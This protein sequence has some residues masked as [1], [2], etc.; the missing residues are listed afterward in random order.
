MILNQGKRCLPRYLP[1][2]AKVHTGYWKSAIFPPWVIKHLKIEV[3][4]EKAGSETVTNIEVLENRFY[5][6]VVDKATGSISS[7]FDKELNH[8][9]L[10]GDNPYNIGQ[11]VRETTAERN[12]RPEK[13]GFILNHT[14]VSNIKVDKGVNGPVWESIKI[15]FDLDGY[16][17]GTEGSPR[18]SRWRSDYYKNIKKIEFRYM[19]RKLIV[20]DPEALY[21]TFPFSM[22]GSRIVFE[23][24]GGT[25]TQGQ[26]L[27][28]SSSDWNSAQNFVAVRGSSGQI[29]IVSN[30]VPMWQFSDFNMGKRERNPKQ[31][32]TWLYSWVMNNYWDTNFR[33][34]QEGGFSWSYQITSSAD[35][36]NT[37]AAKYAW[38]ERNPFPARTFPAGANDL[39]ST[40]LSTLKI[41]G[42]PN[43]LLMNARPAFKNNPTLLLR[44]REL[45]GKSAEVYLASSVPGRALTKIVEVNSTGK[46]IGQPVTTI[47]FS[48]YEVKF[49]EVEF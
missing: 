2:D 10:D 26:Q 8:E 40:S 21:V 42:S 15:S 6:L 22:P 47:Q 31:G 36:T 11:L 23:T 48:P 29:V 35:T 18:V 28:G 25:L 1:D 5:K 24:T 34:Y 49:I 4:V 12:A 9:L 46:Q 14:T 7:L 13:T 44:F 41:T 30:E 33:A 45:E 37:F 3:A 32:K 38:G 39:K 17:K 27:P 43:A 16:E 20:I 19:A